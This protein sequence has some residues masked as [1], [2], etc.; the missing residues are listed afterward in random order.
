MLALGVE[1]IVACTKTHH[2]TCGG[3]RGQPGARG[4]RKV[5]EGERGGG[6]GERERERER[7]GGREGGRDI[8]PNARDTSRIELSRLYDHEPPPRCTR[9]RSLELENL[10]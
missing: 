6:R 8:A 5:L 3:V 7:E 4:N 9:S 1:V 2:S 10:Q